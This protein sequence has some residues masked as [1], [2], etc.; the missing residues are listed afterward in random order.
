VSDDLSIPNPGYRGSRAG[1]YGT[2]QVRVQQG[3][4]PDTRRLMM[5]AGC[6]GAVL[7]ALIGA[8]ALMGRH[9]GEVPVVSADPRPVREKPANPG[10]MKI[11][12]ADNDVFSGGSDTSNAKL[13]PAPESPNTKL[14]RAG[15]T[16]SG[17]PLAGSTDASTAMT[18][19]PAA[20]TPAAAA[21]AAAS[22]VTGAPAAGT[23]VA[24]APA[25]TASVAPAPVATAPV[26]T[27]SGAAPA[28]AAGRTAVVPAGKP[29]VVASAPAKP[30]PATASGPAPASGQAVAKPPVAE[31]VHPAAAG[32]T[33]VVQLAALASEYAARAEWTQLMKKMPDLLSGKPPNYSRIERDGRPF[34]RVRTSGFADVAQA[35]SFCEHV[36][37]KGGGCSVAD[38]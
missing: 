16:P 25:A 28:G 36:R 14:L 38:F 26:A 18:G 8:S 15:P 19:T 9:S 2:G 22:P 34:W 21:A 27:A 4:D 31:A 13:A 37:A 29:A 35:R 23:R 17:A 24:A 6:L 12:G 5:F 3:M 20:G 7:V 33:P 1:R 32:H 10:G 11:D 30:V